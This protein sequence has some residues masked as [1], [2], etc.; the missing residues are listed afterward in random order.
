MNMQFPMRTL[1]DRT[2]R[3]KMRQHSNALLICALCVGAIPHVRADTSGEV[4]EFFKEAVKSPPDIESFEA[5]SITLR[6][7][8]PARLRP[9][10]VT[11]NSSQIQIY[12]GARATTNFYLRNL[13]SYERMI[14]GRVEATAYNVAS[15]AVAFGLEAVD[16][17]KP[18]TGDRISQASESAYQ[19]T[20]Q[21]CQMGLGDLNPRSV[22]WMGNEFVGANMSGRSQYGSLE[23]SNNLP[24]SLAIRWRKEEAPFK[25]IN[26]IYPENIFELGGFPKKVIISV[27]FEDGLHPFLELGY[28]NVHLAKHPLPADYFAPSKF[29][30]TNTVYTNTWAKNTVTSASPRGSATVSLGSIKDG[31]QPATWR[32]RAVW[33]FFLFLLMIV[34]IVG[35]MLLKRGKVKS[36]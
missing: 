29:I 25:V 22:S 17:A 1:A 27:L 7:R 28:L 24:C 33:A 20:A 35:A 2:M 14:A 3:F 18:A 8:M 5:S 10:G 9:K 30:A 13:S 4:V 32:Q 19:L 21:F 11:N 12:E 23:L 34:P 31:I 36:N 16:P 26:Y 6:D 15:N